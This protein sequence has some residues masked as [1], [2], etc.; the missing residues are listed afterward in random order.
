MTKEVHFKDARL[1]LYEDKIIHHVNGLKE[2]SHNH[3]MQ[4]ESFFHKIPY[5]FMIQT[6][7][8]IGTEENSLNLI[9]SINKNPTVNIILSGERLNDFP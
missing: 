3:I 8:K 7:R 1:F 5:L 9:A 6:L 2:K 4:C